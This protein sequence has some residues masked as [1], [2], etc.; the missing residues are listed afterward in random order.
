MENNNLINAWIL[1]S[2]DLNIHIEAPFILKTDDGAE[3]TFLILI[4]KFGSKLGT[5]VITTDDFEDLYIPEIYGYYCSALNP[6]S[7]SEYKRDHFIET[8]ED[9]GF[10][11]NSSEKPQ[12]Y[13]GPDYNNG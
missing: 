5:I 4:R 8:L 12:W 10:F 11:G 7:Y 13:N 9:W 2:K 6:L 1:A 3:Y